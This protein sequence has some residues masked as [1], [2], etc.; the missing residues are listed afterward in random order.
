MATYSIGRQMERVLRH[1]SLALAASATALV[2]Q[3]LGYD[4]D[5]I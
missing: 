5:G 4:I 3:S 1:P 2:G